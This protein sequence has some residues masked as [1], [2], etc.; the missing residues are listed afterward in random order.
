MSKTLDNCIQIQIGDDQRKKFGLTYNPPIIELEYVIPSKNKKYKHK[1]KLTKLKTD[2]NM[3]D[4]INYIYK[5]HYTYL[6]SK[7][8]SATQIESK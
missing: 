6:D 7:L 2:S 8:I 5:K 3:N 1:I 4:I